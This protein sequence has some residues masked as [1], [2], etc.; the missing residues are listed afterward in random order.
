MQITLSLDDDAF[1]LVKQYAQVRSLAMGK[2]LSDLVR[3]GVGAP[4]KTRR[5]NGLVVI[6]L[7]EDSP[8]VTSEHVKELES[9]DR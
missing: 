2:A 5:V 8:L 6:E 3:R 7:P 1:Q 9:Q 4:P